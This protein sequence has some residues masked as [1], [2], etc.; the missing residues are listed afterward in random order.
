M[1][2]DPS[3]FLQ[4]AA[5]RADQDKQLQANISASLDRNLK[6]KE[7]GQKGFDL[8]K[9][10][11]TALMKSEMGQTPSPEETAAFNAYQKFEGAKQAFDPISGER[12]SKFQPFGLSGN[13][14]PQGFNLANLPQV[15]SQPIP[16][17]FVGGTNTIDGQEPIPLKLEDLTN[18]SMNPPKP[19]G[20]SKID[21]DREK[22]YNANLL[23]QG[24]GT[25]NG[26]DTGLLPSPF[27]P[28][29]PENNLRV[30]NI[31]FDPANR[32]QA[33]QVADANIDLQKSAKMADLEV[34][35]ETAKKT[36]ENAVNKE[37]KLQ[38]LLPAIDIISTLE[39]DVDKTPSGFIENL[40]AEVT[41]L[42]DVPTKKAIAKGEAQPKLEL[43]TTQLKN[44]I[45]GPGEGTWT[46]AD[47]K[48]LDRL[49]PK[50]NDSTAVKKAKYQAIREELSKLQGGE[51]KDFSGFK[52]LGTED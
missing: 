27:T 50:E 31:E 49:A 18:L 46:D 10:A 43:L 36:A 48:K 1:P 33:G 37:Q 24:N 9:L 41:N 8:E 44:F 12:Y 39:K 34:Q 4:Y 47:Q 16:D 38:A 42:A 13:T 51:Q 30:N 17:T 25:P 45:R 28:I 23:L 5:L 3:M 52:Y 15:E 40:A 2:L 6:A 21:A 20:D 22:A 26:F 14:A 32:K 19:E 29:T 35:K 11:Q 7:L